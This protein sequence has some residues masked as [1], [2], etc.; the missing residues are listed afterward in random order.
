LSHIEPD[1]RFG[2]EDEVCGGGVLLLFSR[3]QI[4]YD[5]NNMMKQ[6]GQS[7]YKLHPDSQQSSKLGTFNTRGEQGMMYTALM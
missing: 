6:L 7:S 5:D 4:L 2:N 3:V 1:K